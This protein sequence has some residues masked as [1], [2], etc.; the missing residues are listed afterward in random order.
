MEKSFQ[1]HLEDV[2]KIGLKNCQER[3]IKNFGKIDSMGSK[4]KGNK[5][6]DALTL[7]DLENQE[8]FLS[9]IYSEVD[10]I[11]IGVEERCE[12]PTELQKQFYSNDGKYGI[13]VTFDPIDGTFCYKNGINK[14]YGLIASL[15]ERIDE[16]HGMFRSVI[17]YSPERDEFLKANEEGVFIE[18]NLGINKLEKKNC[19]PRDEKYSTMNVINGDWLGVSDNDFKND[20]F[21]AVEGIN[22][23]V[24]GKIPGYIISGGS[25]IDNSACAYM[26]HQW[27]ADVVLK[28]GKNPLVVPYFDDFSNGVRKPYSLARDLMI[29]GDK[30]DKYFKKYMEG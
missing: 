27:G 12:D 22:S 16:I 10:F 21:S 19:S 18:N 28:S 25:I 29:I 1:R 4:N 24:S 3:T 8:S 11:E 9:D 26:A 17:V 6:G 13:K 2:I 23:L 5:F 15:L 7:I 30:Q 20:L 14:N